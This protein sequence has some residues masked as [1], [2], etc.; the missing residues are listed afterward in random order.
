MSTITT[1]TIVITIVMKSILLILTAVII[2]TIAT[3]IVITSSVSSASSFT[4]LIHILV[5]VIFDRII[6]LT[7]VVT[8]NPKRVFT[9]K[10]SFHMRL[11]QHL[12]VSDL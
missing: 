12:Q 5:T 1:M 9:T 10:T 11:N 3:V 7:T 2:I 8:L 6:F 4:I